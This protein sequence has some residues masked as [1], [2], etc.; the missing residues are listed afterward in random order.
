MVVPV[1]SLGWEADWSFDKTTNV[2][3]ECAAGSFDIS[4][5]E[6]AQ[7]RSENGLRNI[8]D[9][10]HIQISNISIDG[11]IIGGILNKSDGIIQDLSDAITGLERFVILG[12]K[13]DA[14]QITNI[15]TSVMQSAVLD[16]RRVG[17]VYEDIQF[18]VTR[19]DHET[20]VLV[21]N[22]VFQPIDHVRFDRGALRLRNTCPSTVFPCDASERRARAED[23]FSHILE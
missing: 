19:S 2:T 6:R 14:S 20:L 10:T 9:A 16:G 4:W 11:I 21:P 12:I 1:G 15:Y 13:C 17:I 5:T 23:A 3:F 18:S 22:S 7:T 8:S